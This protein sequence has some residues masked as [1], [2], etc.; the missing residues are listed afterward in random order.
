[1]LNVRSGREATLPLDAYE[2]TWTWQGDAVAY[3]RR[4]ATGFYGDS[5]RVWRRDG[6]G[7]RVLLIDTEN[8][9]LFGI[10]SLRY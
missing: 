1:V 7:E 10:A 4:A 2:A 3:L 8:P 6:S 5:V 9:S